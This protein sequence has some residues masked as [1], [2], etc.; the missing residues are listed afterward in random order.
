MPQNYKRKTQRGSLLEELKTA[1]DAVVKCDK[2]IGS[3][4]AEFNVDRM[5]LSRFIAKQRGNPERDTGYE[6]CK[7]VNMIFSTTMEADRAIHV[8]YMA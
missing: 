7:T 2:S 4:A 3:A 1:A 8:K 6:R 5:T